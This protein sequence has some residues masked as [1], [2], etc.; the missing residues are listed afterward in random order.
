MSERTSRSAKTRLGFVALAALALS[1]AG[2]PRRDTP[3]AGPMGQSGTLGDASNGPNTVGAER[4][5]AASASTSA[6]NSATATDKGSDWVAAVRSASWDAAWKGIQTLS[7]EE[8]AKPEI[9]YVAARV[10]MAR[11]DHASAVTLLKDLE[12]ALPLLA[13]DI[14]RR[15]AEAK[16]H[17]GPYPEAAEY[18]VGRL[19]PK[20]QLKA[21]EAYEKSGDQL[22][23]KYACDRAI[24]HEKRTQEDE[25]EGRM[26]RFKLA[27]DAQDA[28]WFVVSAPAH[29]F[30]HEAETALAR[31]EPQR[32]LSVT[33]RTTRA[34]A[35][36]DAGKVDEALRSLEAIANAPS[37]R[38]TLLA[39]ARL[40]ADI[41]YRSKQRYAEAAR[42]YQE[43]SNIG[44][45]N[46]GEDAFLAARAL[47]RADKDNEAIA[48]YTAVVSR[49]PKTGWAD[50]ASYFVPY[51][52]LLHGRWREAAT[53]FD[54]Y[55]KRWPSGSMRPETTRT[56][57]IARLMM[58]DHKGARKLFEELADD[59]KGDAL[60]FARARTMAALA[61][62]RDGDR[63]HAIAVW[64]EIA[65]THPLSWPAQVARARL[66]EAGAP[67]PPLVDPDTAAPYEPLDVR[68]PPPVDMFHRV[69]LEDD[70][71][72]WLRD[73]ETLV[74]PSQ[75]GR[76]VEALCAAY[77][78]LARA[79]RRSKVA[80]QIPRELLAL[81]PGPRNAWAWSCAYSTPFPEFVAK[82]ETE[83]PVPLGLVYAVMRQES[84]FDETAVSPARAVGLMQLMPETARAT[85]EAMNT[86]NDPPALTNAEHNI[87]LGTRYLKMMLDHFEGRVPL[88]V[89]AYNAGPEAIDRWL[90]RAPGMEMD[91]FVERIPFAETR[92]YVAR[93]VG[94]HAR[95]SYA[96][97]GKD[98]V[99]PL[100]LSLPARR[101]H[102]P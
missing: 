2:C 74:S 32:P 98:A 82:A 93:V 12:N 4:A 48:A 85:A 37:G 59:N 26:R 9:R 46:A 11:D 25:A 84:S 7:T 96:L 33:E 92:G 40:R 78:T 19:T 6:P 41:L 18:F 28:R 88:A 63:T 102:A 45:V 91:V 14:W 69:G 66:E 61:A 79:K 34:R 80:M 24:L 8:R 97:K 38:P 42:A 57:A 73:R 54:D 50:Q 89:A 27:G 64:T 86:P 35:L 60:A 72:S 94:N 43:A 65:R 5:D 75:P 101:D 67:L 16:L 49:F 3:G 21:S 1:Q 44:G 31:L 68:L 22:R 39:Q 62:F 20:S 51:L 10:A 53:G 56:R 30:A 77:G 58:K 76:N 17:A 23:A 29:P 36:A 71:E 55:I 87:R 90:S 95:Y 13:D 15:S 100:V 47:S 52:H 99:A 81:G 70:A 83:S